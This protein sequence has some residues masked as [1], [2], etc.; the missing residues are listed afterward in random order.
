ML[1]RNVYFVVII[2][3]INIIMVCINIVII[4]IVVI[5]II[6]FIQNF[7]LCPTKQKGKMKKIVLPTMWK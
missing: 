7:I 1:F 3:V 6:T 5:I 4:I 2:I